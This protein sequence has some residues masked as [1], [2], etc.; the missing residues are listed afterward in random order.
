MTVGSEEEDAAP[1]SNAAL[2]VFG[3]VE[4]AEIIFLGLS[5]RDVLTSTQRVCREWKSII[6]GSKPIQQALFQTPVSNERVA[7]R[8]RHARRKQFA[9]DIL[10]HPVLASELHMRPGK[11]YLS[12]VKWLCTEHLQ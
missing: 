12:F 4:L 10:N 1:A 8:D 3:T 9:P 2:K 11:P 5:M 7:Y 6:E